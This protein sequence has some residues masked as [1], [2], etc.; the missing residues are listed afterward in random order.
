M[1]SVVSLLFPP[2]SLQLLNPGNDQPEFLV[3][4][5]LTHKFGR[6]W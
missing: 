4:F 2:D 3:Q 1:F 6:L 5:Y